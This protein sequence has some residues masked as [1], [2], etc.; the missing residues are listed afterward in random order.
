ML[1]MSKLTDYATVLLAHMA[2]DQRIS[3]A[4]ELAEATQLASPTVSKLLKTLAKAKLVDSVRGP[5]G[6]YTLARQPEQI[7]AADIIDALEGPVAITECSAGA[8]HCE[9]EPVCHVGSAWQRINHGIRKAL[10]EV[11]LVDLQDQPSRLPGLNLSAEAR[12]VASNANG[13]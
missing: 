8:G 4:G 3:S 6:G 7:S 1:R 13:A 5:H 9:L 12:G 10:G 11:S 2:H